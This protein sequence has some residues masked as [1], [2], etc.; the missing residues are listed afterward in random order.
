MTDITLSSKCF[1]SI[2]DQTNFS[3]L[4]YYLFKIEMSQT[5]WFEPETFFSILKGGQIISILDSVNCSIWTS[6]VH[7]IYII[8][9][10]KPLHLL[11]VGLS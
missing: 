9:T 1:G 11:F 8:Y 2:H 5:L 3:W 7:N 4:I 10:F 6:C